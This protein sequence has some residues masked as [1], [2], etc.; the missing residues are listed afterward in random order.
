MIPRQPIYRPREVQWLALLK[1]VQSTLANSLESLEGT[2]L[3]PGEPLY[4]AWASVFVGKAADGYLCLR[5]SGRV[6]ASK[7][8]VRPA[9][10]ATLSAMAVLKQ[11]GFLF[12]KL[13]TELEEEKKML[14]KS[15]AGIADA[16]RVLYDMEAAAKTARPGSPVERKKVDMAY[17]AKMAGQSVAYE[18]TY[19]TYCK[20]AHGTMQAVQGHLDEATDTVDTDVVVWCVL[21]LL[22]LLRQHTVADVPDLEPFRKRLP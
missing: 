17:T 10:E 19:R 22:D 21:T 14:R 20:F 5:E 3:P 7:L 1:D 15:P 9:L 16:D 12:R 18:S 8:L 6:P 2:S 13:Y 11:P 4:L